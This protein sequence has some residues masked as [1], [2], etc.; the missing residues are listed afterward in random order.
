MALILNIGL[1]GVQPRADHY[2]KKMTRADM[3]LNAVKALN[4]K[5]TASAVVRS[6]TEETL[7]VEC[8]HPGDA[9]ACS[10]WLAEALHQ[11]CIAVWVNRLGVGAYGCL[12]G[13][14]AATWGDFNPEFFF[15]LDGTRMA[16][17]ATA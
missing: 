10:Y 9:N 16:Q 8:E 4:F 1:D 17:P 2:G 12:V 14:R 6:D 5:V 7:V 3:A 11:D 13:P 15:R